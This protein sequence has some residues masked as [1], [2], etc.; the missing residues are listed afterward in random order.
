M[1]DLLL[2]QL[3]VDHLLLGREII[4][5]D[6]LST[7]LDF[8]LMILTLSILIFITAFAILVHDFTSFAIFIVLL[9]LHLSCLKH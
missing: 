1:L 4:L 7:T 5:F 2:S 6:L 8:K 9:L 3:L